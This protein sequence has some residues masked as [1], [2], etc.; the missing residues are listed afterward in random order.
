MTSRHNKH[1]ATCLL[2]GLLLPVAALLLGACNEQT[3]YHA[4]QPLPDKGW[5]RQDTVEFYAEVPDSFTTYQLYVEIRNNTAYP[6][7]N[8]PL[9]ITSHTA[10]TIP[11][12]TDTLQCILANP[13][14][15][16][17][18]QGWGSMFLS[19]FPAGDIPI[20]KTGSYRFQVAYTLSDPLLKGISDIGIRLAKKVQHLSASPSSRINAQ[21]YKQ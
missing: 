4:Y 10:D 6:Y 3:V 2:K 15:H 12:R 13:Q 21:E 1:K 14:G 9:S 11:L 17:T 16:W 20:G 8:L 18:G 7:R 5:Q 19:A